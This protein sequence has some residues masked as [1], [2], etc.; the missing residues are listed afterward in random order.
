MKKSILFLLLF[1]TKISFATSPVDYDWSEKPNR[2]TL[3]EEEK[4]LS[5]L[6][7]LDTRIFNFIIDENK[8]EC[9]ETQHKIIR[10]N[11]D[12]ALDRENK[13][14]IPMRGVKDILEI[15]ARAIAPDGKVTL[16]D[17]NN[18]KE[19]D[20]LENY[21]Q[22]KIFAVEGAVPGSDIEYYYKV[23][24]NLMQYGVEFFQAEN[25][26]RDLN[27]YLIAPKQFEFEVQT[28]NGLPKAAESEKDGLRTLHVN[29]KN[30]APA[31]EEEYAANRSNLAKIAFKLSYL[32]KDG[33]RS[34]RLN[35]WDNIT[36]RYSEILTTNRK[37]IDFKDIF[38]S[39]KIKKIKSEEDKIIAIENYIKKNIA[40]KE[41]MGENLSEVADVLEQKYA[42]D[43]GIAKLYVAFFKELEIPFEIVLS[44]SRYRARFDENFE[45]YSNIDKML[46]YF[47][48]YD[49]FISPER[50]DYRLG[51]APA[52]LGGNYGLFIAGSD[53][54]KVK[55]INPSK[56]DQSLVRLE[57]DVEFDKEMEY[58]TMNKFRQTTGHR[59][60]SMRFNLAYV[61]EE[62]R[63]Q[64]EQWLFT[65]GIEEAE[66]LE[67]SLENKDIELSAKPATPFITKASVKAPSLLEKAGNA[68]LFKV[69]L[70]IGTQSE[71]YQETERVQPID[72]EYAKVYNHFIRFDIPKGYKI[73]N[74]DDVKIEKYLKEDGKITAQF[75]SSYDRRGDSVEIRIVEFY[76]KSQYP[77]D[78]YEDFR[79]V[80]NAAADFNKVTFVLEK[81]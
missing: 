15:K 75:V 59:A 78:L 44:T 18:I 24:K 20:N 3:S 41:G 1:I 69:G 67:S 4:K 40:Y 48:K 37:K 39:L 42:D 53:E 74:L 68:F 17:K 35:T 23:R 21:G 70:A 11:D 72:F 49:K 71:L 54:G 9:I 55:K 22:F 73:E 80:I 79:S 30:L 10:V 36:S 14:F 2:T 47:S 16:L 51:I 26:V 25:K 76:K 61:N 46:F 56:D 45:D 8:E 12:K 33:M 58:I 29:T 63:Q 34:P 5:A 13:V 7:V 64:L 50:I 77:K 31:I 65:S 81:I 43:L 60:N 57:I 52:D 6:T 28:Y 66:I 27:F 32:N 38:K 19:I 62:G